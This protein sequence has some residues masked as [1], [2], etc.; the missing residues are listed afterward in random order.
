M[1]Q[2]VLSHLPLS[3]QSLFSCHIGC[4]SPFQPHGASGLHDLIKLNKQLHKVWPGPICACLV[5]MFPVVFL[6]FHLSIEGKYILTSKLKGPP[7]THTH[8]SKLHLLH[9]FT[10]LDNETLFLPVCCHA[11]SRINVAWCSP[12]CPLS[13]TMY[14]IASF[15]RQSPGGVSPCL[16]ERSWNRSCRGGP[17]SYCILSAFACTTSNLWSW[18]S[19]T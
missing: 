13:L 5:I 14:C 18:C 8:P 16:Y 15:D 19:V 9:L 12:L 1:S 6:T 4:F 17:T 3:P 2:C 11:F 7:P 10:H